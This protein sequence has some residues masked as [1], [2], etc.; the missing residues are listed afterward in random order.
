VNPDDI[1]NVVAFGGG[2]LMDIGCYAINSARLLMGEEP[3]EVQALVRR[4]PTF[5]TDVLTSAALGFGERHATFTVSTQAEP[6]QRV[7]VVG[8]EG[9]LTVE[10]PFNI[11]LDRP[12]RLLVTAGGDP[13]VSPNTEVVEIP[14]ADQYRVQVEAFARAVLEDLEVPIPPRDAVANMRVIER[15]LASAE[16]VPA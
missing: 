7:H 3:T 6:D 2:A 9:R 11:P 16:G 13:P 12:T 8:T 5:G 1:R 4:D 10:I 14:A 15:V